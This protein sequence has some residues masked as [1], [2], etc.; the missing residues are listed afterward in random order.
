VYA[1]SFFLVQ[2]HVRSEIQKAAFQPPLVMEWI[3]QN[4]CDDESQELG[5]IKNLFSQPL[6]RRGIISGLKSLSDK[7]HHG[8]RFPHI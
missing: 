6:H 1:D 7:A 8:H 4:T 5:Y 2:S 3:G